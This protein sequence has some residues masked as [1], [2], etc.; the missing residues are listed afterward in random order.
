MSAR[1]TPAP[2]ALVVDVQVVEVDAAGR[3]QRVG[4]DAEVREPDGPALVVDGERRLQRV[5]LV[6][7]P[8]QT[9]SAFASSSS[10]S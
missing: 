1:P 8:V 6:A 2:R 10:V 3:L 7:D 4:H 5:V 9:M